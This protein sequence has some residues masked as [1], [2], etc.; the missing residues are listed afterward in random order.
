MNKNLFLKIV[1]TT[2]SFLVLFLLVYFLI[3][4]G[5]FGFVI[6]AYFTLIMGS[7]LR[8]LY[9]YLFKE[10]N[11]TQ[12]LYLFLIIPVIVF[13]FILNRN[14]KILEKEKAVFQKN[15]AK[16]KINSML[17]TC[18]Y[19][20]AK[21]YEN[22]LLFKIKKDDNEYLASKDIKTYSK[23]EL[24]KHNPKYDYLVPSFIK[25]PRDSSELV[26]IF[27]NEGTLSVILKLKDTD[28]TRLHNLKFYLEQFQKVIN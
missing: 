7:L 3:H 28:S 27:D 22:N 10:D 14:N 15:F 8:K 11:F 25:C 2:V 19:Y 24:L 21:L 12:Y 20:E 13:A 9:I 6:G 5:V 23:F 16:D 17:D 26:Y 1:F 4:D 18:N